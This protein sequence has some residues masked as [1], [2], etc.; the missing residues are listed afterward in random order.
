MSRASVPP[1]P[2]KSHTETNYKPPAEL[3]DLST[4]ALRLLRPLTPMELQLSPRDQSTNST[5]LRTKPSD[6]PKR[7]QA[8]AS[9]GDCN[10][11]PAK[12]T[13]MEVQHSP[14]DLSTNVT[15]LRAKRK[16]ANAFDG[17]CNP[18]PA[19]RAHAST[20]LMTSTSKSVCSKYRPSGNAGR[21]ANRLKRTGNNM[22]AGTS[23]QQSASAQTTRMDRMAV[24]IHTP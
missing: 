16:Q 15:K 23:S 3:S 4:A 11:A 13:P 14:R 6:C 18:A 19:K 2:K 1:S 12:L 10:P 17:D 21:A 5:E 22:S 9:G 24:S 20:Q 8:N 7:K